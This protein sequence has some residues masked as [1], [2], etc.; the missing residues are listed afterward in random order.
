[1]VSYLA[2][3]DP[4]DQILV[5]DPFFCMYRD[6]A[7]LVNAEPIYYDTY[8]NFSVD[9]AKIESQI[10]PRTKA[11]IVNSPSNPTGYALKESEL[12]QILEV[13]AKADLWVLYDEIYDAFS[14]DAPHCGIIGKYSKAISMGGFSKSHG[15]TGWRVGYAAGSRAIINEMLKIQQYTFVCAPSMAQ[16][17]LVEALD[18][19]I[20]SVAE[21]YRGKRDFM[22]NAL[23]DRFDMVV[24]GGAFYLFPKAPGGRGQ[25]FVERCIARDLLVVPGHVF[26]RVDTHFR[27]SFA[28]P[29]ETLERGAE[30]LN[31]L[32]LG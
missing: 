31:E 24:P 18:Q 3:L 16:H 5:P 20:S 14:Y 25:E 12:L 26:S 19:D 21:D 13:A 4:G 8:P 23:K 22:V 30:V 2:T 1:M 17:A 11:I 28:A 15:A 7:L 29:M 6:L 10:T 32:A 27:I 9:A